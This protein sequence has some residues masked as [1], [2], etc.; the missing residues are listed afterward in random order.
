VGSIYAAHER[1][2]FSS[3][4]WAH[5]DIEWVVADGPAP[6][7]STGIAGMAQG[8]RDFVGL[9]EDYRDELEEIRALDGE[10]VLVLVRLH[11][12]GKTSRLEIGQ[13]HT[14]PAVLMH[15]REGKVTGSSTTSTAS[16]HRPTSGSRRRART[17][18]GLR[19]ARP[20][21]SIY[22]AWGRCEVKNSPDAVSAIC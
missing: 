15:L 3:A 9:W 10:R 1:G 20:C 22:A 5:P 6:G 18:D 21:C 16:A 8:W 2:D 17:H 4:Q 12:R 14:R 7:T 13:I 11:G 19:E